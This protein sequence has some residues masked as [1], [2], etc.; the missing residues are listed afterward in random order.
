[1]TGQADLMII[2]GR[3]SAASLVKLFTI[4]RV[5]VLSSGDLE[6]GLL[7]HK[8]DSKINAAL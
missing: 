3:F 7:S 5:G 6:V 8:G 4:G 1:M 2:A